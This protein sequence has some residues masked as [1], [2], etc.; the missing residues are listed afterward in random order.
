MKQLA[1]IPLN[2]GV[3]GMTDG[4]YYMNLSCILYIVEMQLP[5]ILL[6]ILQVCRHAYTK[7]NNC[8][9]ISTK[10]SSFQAVY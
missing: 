10:W 7:W 9:Y 3:H 8:H 1:C 2:S 5:L 4:E 6:H